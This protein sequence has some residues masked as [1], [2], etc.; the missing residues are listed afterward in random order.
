MF[1]YIVD[2][3]YYDCGYIYSMAFGGPVQWLLR[4]YVVY[5]REIFPD[6]YI[7]DLAS[8]IKEVEPANTKGLND[9]L[10][11]ILNAKD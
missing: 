3:T 5:D 10:T 8:E 11:G 6:K 2:N 7:G 4:N 1:D 9:L